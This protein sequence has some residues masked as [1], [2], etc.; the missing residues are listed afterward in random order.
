M[1]LLSRSRKTGEITASMHRV[2]DK[3]Q[4]REAGGASEIFHPW[5]RGQSSAAGRSS[6]CA[7]EEQIFYSGYGNNQ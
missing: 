5:G 1:R 4:T 7:F 6:Q 2:T 3:M